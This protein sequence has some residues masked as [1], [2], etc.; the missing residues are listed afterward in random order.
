MQ[1]LP[2]PPPEEEP[3]EP[4]DFSP[5]EP[6][7]DII[8]EISEDRPLECTECKKKIAVR[9]TKVVGKTITHTAMCQ[10]CPQLQRRLHGIPR[11]E[12]IEAV[13]GEGALA[14]GSCGTILDSV[15][16]GSLLGCSSCYEVFEDILLTEMLKVQ[17]I[18]PKVLSR[19]KTSPIHIG[20]A[21]GETKEINPSIQLMALNEALTE[22]LRKED[23]EQAAWLRDQIKVIK[24][25]KDR[26]VN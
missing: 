1:E 20:R 24:E 12:P 21:I 16:M 8:S 17:R 26:E 4:K 9:Y 6:P 23:Y 5:E 14:C 13:I 19:K 10:D 25:T 7:T 15:R 3:S 22:M 2:P 11:M 18:S